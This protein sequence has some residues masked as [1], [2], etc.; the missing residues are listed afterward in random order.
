LRVI[1]PDSCISSACGPSAA[2]R[3]G[4]RASGGA[5]LRWSRESQGTSYG[6]V[7]PERALMDARA[8]AEGPTS[9][10]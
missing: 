1:D 6:E 10:E 9:T 5:R 3:R 7:S 8:E 4:A 2:R